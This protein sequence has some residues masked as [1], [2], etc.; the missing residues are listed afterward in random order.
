MAVCQLW[1]LSW[2]AKG[3]SLVILQEVPPRLWLTPLVKTFSWTQ[4][5]KEQ[6]TRQAQNHHPCASGLEM[7]VK[8]F[9]SA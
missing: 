6:D 8:L 7:T 1:V 5:V 2:K 4:A 9:S 3:T